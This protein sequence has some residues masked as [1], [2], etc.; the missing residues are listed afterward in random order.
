MKTAIIFSIVCVSFASAQFG[1]LLGGGAG[2]G[3]GVSAGAGAGRQGG[4]SSGFGGLFDVF[5]GAAH[6]FE[7]K[8]LNQLY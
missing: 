6:Q 3:G 8:S 2:G 7:S 4:A 1:S 5:G